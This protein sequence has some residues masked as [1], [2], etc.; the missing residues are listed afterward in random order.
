M[1]Y[2]N[3]FKFLKPLLIM[4]AA[5]FILYPAA[6]RTDDGDVPS[7]NW[8]KENPKPA[9]WYWGE[10][11][12]KNKPVH[13]GYLRQANSRYVGLMN[14]NHWPVNDWGAMSNMYEAMT[15]TDHEFKPT[16]N[17]LIDSW[18][19]TGPKTVV[20]VIKK[21][22]KFHDGAQL[23]A[24]GVKYNFDWIKDK[25]NGAWTRSAL[26]SM[27][28]IEVLDKYTLQWNFNSPW[29][30]FPGVMGSAPGHIMSPKA[31]KGDEALVELGKLEKKVA[32][33]KKKVSK[34]EKKVEKAA[35]KGGKAAKKAAKKAKK[36]KKKLAKL[37]KGLKKLQVE[38]AGAFPLDTHAVGTG[39]YMF[40]EGRPGNYVKMKRNP[41][42]WFG[43][44][45]GK[46][47]MP[48]YDGVIVSV[49]PDMSVRLANLR[50]GKLDFMGIEASQ[51]NLV[52]NDPNLS[53]YTIPTNH[54]RNF[55][56]NIAKGPCKDIRVRKAIAHAIDRKA[57]VHGT[58]FGLATE[59]S[60]VYPANHWAHNPD[61]KPVKYDPEL[62]KKLLA[63]AGYADGL[64]IKGYSNGWW[65]GTVSQA[66]QNMLKKVNIDWQYDIVDAVAED[67]RCKNLEYD[68][69]SY[70][71]RYITDPDLMVS[72]TY[73]PNGAWNKGRSNNKKAVAIIEQARS[74]LN[75]DKRQKLYWK[76][77]E[78]LYDNYEDVWLYYPLDVVAHSKKIKGYNGKMHHQ[79]GGGYWFTHPTWFKNGKP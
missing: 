74:E 68:F 34:L 17:W 41:N 6:A 19:F 73:H 26:D 60:S 8:T 15:Y 63:E 56:F 28:S 25:K 39:Q 24:K 78:A 69:A 76:L 79:G 67:D 13:G 16:I 64:T 61:L 35:A 52:K 36:E 11:Y 65:A 40:E 43:Q 48:Y 46:P 5:I 20:M 55:Y 12:D 53:V 47:E 71:F 10:E 23:T 45:I 51:Y 75:V 3:Q 57:I 72:A 29:A 50:A 9:W 49:I 38:A 18:K 37:E 7:W 66:M 54:L 62:S 30:S 42:W 27:K 70:G 58:Q 59:A 31:L 21:G 22:I 14:P 4:M 2:T 77:E 33:S 1:K 44:S 32:S